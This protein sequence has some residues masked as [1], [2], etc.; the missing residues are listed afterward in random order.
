MQILFKNTFTGY[1]SYL[2]F[3]VMVG[4][5]YD[6]HLIIC[7]VAVKMI[8]K[9]FGEFQQHVLL[10]IVSDTKAELGE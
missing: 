9:C 6:V 3:E 2:I 10:R 4:N 7:E 5:I 1:N 8:E